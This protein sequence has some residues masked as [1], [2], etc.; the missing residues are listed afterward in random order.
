[1]TRSELGEL[2]GLHR[3]VGHG[4]R[5]GVERQKNFGA[6]KRGTVKN[7]LAGQDPEE[8]QSDSS[9]SIPSR[10]GFC[11][12]RTSGYPIA[13]SFRFSFPLKLKAPTL[14]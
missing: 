5:E 13:I 8:D 9:H 4:Q 10:G 12:G 14:C 1:M 2:P 3:N 7:Q 6:G 11:G